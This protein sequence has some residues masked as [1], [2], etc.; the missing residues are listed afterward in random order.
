MVCWILGLIALTAPAH[1]SEAYLPYV[2]R[3]AD[4]NGTPINGEVDTRV[5]LY[6]D[7][8]SEV[9]LWQTTYDDVPFTDG[10]FELSLTGDDIQ[11]R[12]LDVA[13][14]SDS[15]WVGVAVDGGQDLGPTKRLATTG[16]IR[17]TDV[18]ETCTSSLSG[19]MRYRDG[20]VQ[21][22]DADAWRYV[23]Q[24]PLAVGG[25][26]STIGDETIHTFTSDGTFTA[27]RSG[28]VQVLIVGGGGA[29]GSSLT[30]GGGGGAVL[31]HPALEISAQDY[32]ITIGTGGV[33]VANTGVAGG[34]GG[35]TTAFGVTAT[36]GAGA[37]G[38]YTV[39]PPTGQ[40][41][42]GGG[43]SDRRTNQ[44]VGVAPTPGGGWV[45]HAGHDGGVGGGTSPN[46]PGG[47]GAGAGG[48]GQS[49]SSASAAA[50]DGGGH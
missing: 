35:A 4:V 26:V 32:P 49:P 44:G 19:V 7:A 43:A 12:S 45:V 21:F 9:V 18:D 38:R 39:N 20:G 23:Y 15:L 11:D 1:A 47:G 46:Y 36:G 40:A 3:L 16:F 33:G 8:S 28:T 13:L 31:Y 42:G 30:G 6:A 10:Y 41:N 37:V 14:A 17:L 22:C 48:N 34:N 2:G 24:P 29:G 27:L 25:A 5:T 50:G